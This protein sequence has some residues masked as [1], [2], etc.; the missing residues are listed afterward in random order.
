VIIELVRSTEKVMNGDGGGGGEKV[1]MAGA[2]YISAGTS[3]KICSFRRTFQWGG[4][5][6]FRATA[7]RP[8][9][10]RVLCDNGGRGLK[11]TIL[12]IAH[13]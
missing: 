1:R 6:S 5:Q 8:N 12:D 9:H 4:G 10:R 2:T 7:T 11:S 3:A 13:R